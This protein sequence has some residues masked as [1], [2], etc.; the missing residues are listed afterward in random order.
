MSRIESVSFTVMEGYM[1]SLYLKFQ[2]SSP[3]GLGLAVSLPKAI[4]I[5]MEVD[6]GSLNQLDSM[7]AATETALK[8]N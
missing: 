7:S 1:V 4:F 3:R 6:P 2:D 8:T 5:L